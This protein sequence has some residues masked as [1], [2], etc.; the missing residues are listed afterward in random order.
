MQYNALMGK[1][2][3]SREDSGRII[4]SGAVISIALKL[5]R[6]ALSLTTFHTSHSTISFISFVQVVASDWAR[7]GM[8]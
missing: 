1:L 5:H 2:V 4:F 8:L 3:F 6:I 7:Q